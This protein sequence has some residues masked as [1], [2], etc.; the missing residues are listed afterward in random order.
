MKKLKFLIPAF[1]LV[2]MTNAGCSDDA[3]DDDQPAVTKLALT[4]QAQ[5]ALTFVATSPEAQ[6][7]P[8]DT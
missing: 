3:G 1:A 6:V 4:A 8:L 5:S 2:A 7:L